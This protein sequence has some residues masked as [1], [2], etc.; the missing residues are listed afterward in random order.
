MLV[1]HLYFADTQ[2]SQNKRGVLK[3]GERGVPFKGQEIF[4]ESKKDR[5]VD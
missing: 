3:R 4:S 1:N 2:F 5:Q